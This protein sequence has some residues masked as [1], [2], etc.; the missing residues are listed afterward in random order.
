MMSYKSRIRSAALAW[1][2]C[3]SCTNGQERIALV[4][5]DDYGS[6]SCWF[7]ERNEFI[8]FL[9]IARDGQFAVPYMV[10]ANC[11]ISG[12]YS[13]FGEAL[14]HHLTEIELTDSSAVLGRAFPELV[15]SDNIQTDLPL[16]SSDSKVYYF[17]GRLVAVSDRDRSR[18]SI[19]S[20]SELT[21][22]QVTFE[23]FLS[24]SRDGRASLISLYR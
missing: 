3:V 22:T 9:V 10:S 19:R 20:I 24:L 13:S 1:L 15:V 14:I 2:L 11:I 18:Y 21:D 5:S 7:S 23:H 16:P 8:S 4:D 12:E 6:R 17:R